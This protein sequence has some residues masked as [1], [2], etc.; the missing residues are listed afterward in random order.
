M[1]RARPLP[2]DATPLAHQVHKRMMEL[3]ISQKALALRAGLNQTYVRDLFTG[4]TRNP[5][6]AHLEKLAQALGCEIADLY[7]DP[8]NPTSPTGPTGSA[9]KPSCAAANDQEKVDPVDAT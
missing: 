4:H 9:S 3:G 6:Y 1:R 5:K 8:A 2:Q 7:P